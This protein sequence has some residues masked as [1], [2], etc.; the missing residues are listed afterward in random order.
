MAKVNHPQVRRAYSVDGRSA[1]A[2]QGKLRL[3]VRAT[4]TPDHARPAAA[5]HVVQI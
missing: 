1:L 2:G 4:G 5:T 3:R